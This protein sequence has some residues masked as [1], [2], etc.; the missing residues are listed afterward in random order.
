MVAAIINRI[1]SSIAERGRA[2]A[3]LPNYSNAE[4]RAASLAQELLSERGEAAGAARAQALIACYRTLD[5]EQRTRFQAY[6]ANHF[7]PDTERLRAAAE[8]FLAAPTPNTVADLTAASEPPRQELLRRIN[9]APGATKT[10]IEMRED[11]LNAGRAP[12]LRP[13]EQDLRHLLGSWFNRGFLELRRIDWNTS[14]AILEKL[15]AYEAVHE[16]HGW[17]DLRR[18]LAPDRRCFAFFHPAMSDEPLIFVEVALCVGM[19]AEIAPLLARDRAI[20][21]TDRAD[22][23]MFYSISNCQAGLRGISFGNFLIKQ[24]VEELRAELP[25]LK[26]FATLSPV[27]SFRVWLDGR[28]AAGDE[29]LFS[30]EMRA[31]LTGNSDTNVQFPAVPQLTNMLAQFDGTAPGEPNEAL[32]RLTLLRLC[33]QYLTANNEGR[34]PDDPVARFHLGNGAGL[35]RTNAGGNKSL[36]GMAES[37]GV[38]V[39]YVYDPD[40]IEANHEKF[41]TQGGVAYGAQI[42][43]L[44]ADGSW[45]AYRH[46]LSRSLQKA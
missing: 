25:K 36:R 40:L 33:A 42:A 35:E 6:L 12:E 14:A 18:R 34:G 13:L 32:L 43:E 27:P 1:W 16:I 21:D 28:L 10:L 29:S 44:L 20:V 24:V 38:M 26:R 37:Y 15:I 2:L 41:A 17:D 5:A 7:L 3:R 39:N 8:R 30:P 46:R 31:A 22:T 11:L 23:A 45:R 4:T 9:V 19:A